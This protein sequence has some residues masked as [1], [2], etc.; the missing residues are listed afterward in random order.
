MPPFISAECPKCNHKNRYDLAEL[1]KDGGYLYKGTVHRLVEADEE[2]A[3]TC[4][5]CGGRFK[6]TVPRTDSKQ[7]GYRDVEAE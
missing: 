6:I 7:G 5:K 2:L 4:E 3:V 1:K